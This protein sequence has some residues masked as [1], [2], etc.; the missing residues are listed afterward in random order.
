MARCGI[1]TIAKLRQRAVASCSL[2]SVR[3]ALE[4]LPQHHIN[5]FLSPVFV[6]T[7][8]F[9]SPLSTAT[10]IKTADVSSS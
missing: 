5:W 8:C 2:N 10:A 1:L 3:L 6:M 7:R 4:H 9:G